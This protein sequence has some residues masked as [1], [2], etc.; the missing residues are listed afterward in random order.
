METDNY[1]QMLIDSLRMKQR[2]LEQLVVLNEEQS[3]LVSEGSMD[4][5][6][7][8]DNMEAKG[9]LIENMIKLD[10][11]FNSV[12]ERVKGQLEGKRAAYQEEIKTMQALIKMVTALGAQVE[13]QEA[14]NKALVESKF[15]ELRKDL[16]NAKRSTQ[17]TNVYYQNM[18]KINYEPQFMDQKK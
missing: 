18:N 1:I 4:E 5:K 10:E 13:V 14:R 15:A 3:G 12:F 17:K 16:Q 9:D 11:G 8:Q 6:A 2:I 7:F